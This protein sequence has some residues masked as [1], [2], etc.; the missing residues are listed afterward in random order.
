MSESA[1]TINE[2][3]DAEN[4][5]AFFLVVVWWSA[6]PGRWRDHQ[7]NPPASVGLNWLAAD[8]V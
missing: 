2:K 4:S 5:I 3:G 1:T 8:A 6:L 7:G